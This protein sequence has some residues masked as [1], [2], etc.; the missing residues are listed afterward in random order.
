M[1]HDTEFHRAF[2]R[3]EG[4]LDGVI[5]RLDVERD[6][7]VALETRVRAIEDRPDLEN[8]VS[9]LEE[10]QSKHSAKLAYWS[11]GLAV[12]AGLYALFRAKL[13]RLFT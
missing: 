9:K 8:R 13:E 5:M 4:K 2:G 12:L 1:E 11:G 10:G 7:R 3:I 6:A